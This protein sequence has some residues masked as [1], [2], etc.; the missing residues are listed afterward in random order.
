MSLVVEVTFI[1]FWSRSARQYSLE[2]H[3]SNREPL[4]IFN[5]V[6][7]H[8]G[9]VLFECAGSGSTAEYEVML[10][11]C[12]TSE[13]ITEIRKQSRSRR[14]RC[15]SLGPLV[16]EQDSGFRQSR[17]AAHCGDGDGAGIRF[18]S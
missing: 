13:M 8:A 4:Q 15:V 7:V 12:P 9:G 2:H 3:D 6:Q 11:L 17:K 5:T 1:A 10:P 18:A 16:Q 14:A